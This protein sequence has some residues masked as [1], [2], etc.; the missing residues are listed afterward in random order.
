MVRLKNRKGIFVVLFGLLFMVLMGAAAISIDM[1]RIWTMRN[2]LQTAA[3]AGALAGAVQLTPPHDD[4]YA[5][6]ND[7]ARA[8]ARL[9][10]ALYDL[11]TVDFVHTGVWDDDA[12]TFTSP[13][14]G[15]PNAVHVQ[16]SH[17]TNKLI[18]GALGIA[19]PVVRAR[20]I[21]W[22]NAPINTANCIRPWSM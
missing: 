14:P 11:V 5:M 15:S 20:A 4:A 12:G 8:I 22:A 19:A 17:G 9:N 21:A 10:T 2:E 16:V 6:V 13:G 18:M 7:S 3:D 1:S